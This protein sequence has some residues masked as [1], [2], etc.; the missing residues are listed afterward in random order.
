MNK[1]WIVSCVLILTAI[2]FINCGLGQKAENN[3]QK[4]IFIRHGEKPDKG[5]NLSCQGFNRALQL[6]DILQKKIGMPNAILV[7]SMN[8]GKKTSV[9]RMYQTIVPFAVKYNLN[10]N[11]KYNVDE[12]DKIVSGLQKQTGTVLMVWEHKNISKIVRALGIQ[13][14]D[15]WDDND[16]DSIWIVTYKNGVPVLTKTSE[17]LQ[18]ATTCP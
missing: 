1:I 17:G 12:I 8:E 13:N 2:G 15:K 14:A 7:P 18:P 5:D 11:T 10:I 3:P 9:A 16:F 6:A 4:I